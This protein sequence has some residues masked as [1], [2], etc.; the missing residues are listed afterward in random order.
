METDWNKY[1]QARPFPYSPTRKIT[2]K[3]V[4]SEILK[5][6]KKKFC[7]IMELGGG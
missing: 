2:E 7:L 4:L 6:E 5:V 3:L 1:Y